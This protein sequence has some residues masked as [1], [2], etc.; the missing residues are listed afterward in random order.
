MLER[1]QIAIYFACVAFGAV[2]GLVLHLPHALIEPALAVMMFATFLQ[3]PLLR[4]AIGGRFMAALLMANFVA[5]PVLVL[6]LSRFLPDDPLIRLGFYLVLFAPCIDY[7]I[8]FAQMGRADSLQLVA[9]TPVLLALQMLLLPVYL[10][11][12]MGPETASIGIA[13]F[14][15]AFLW[16]IVLPLGVAWLVQS[17]TGPGIRQ[18]LDLLPVPA[19]G[20]VLC[21]VTA[22]TMPVLA[23]AIAAAKTV[24]PLYL[25]FA[26]IAP[27][28]GLAVAR[29]FALPPRQARAVSFSAAT[30]N[31]LVVLPVGLAIPGAMPTVAAVIVTQT[32]IELISQLIYIRAIPRLIRGPQQCRAP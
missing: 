21:L 24:A 6:G 20:L 15:H 23:Q 28:I 16:L 18:R 19:T 10:S 4:P 27:L 29:G 26:V 1:H 32:L 22:A 8:T 7:V 2:L 31:S 17:R 25:A 14:V 30:R 11:A 3:V 13:P 12:A 5:V 9:A